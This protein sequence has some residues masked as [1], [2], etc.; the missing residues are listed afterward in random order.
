MLLYSYNVESLYF[1]YAGVE[2]ILLIQLFIFS[3][4]NQQKK[5]TLVSNRVEKD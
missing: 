1:L 2:I 5:N 3:I 4:F